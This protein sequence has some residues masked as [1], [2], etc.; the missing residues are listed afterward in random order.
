MHFQLPVYCPECNAIY[1]GVMQMVAGATV[2][3]QNVKFQCP[4]GHTTQMPDGT[5]EV[6]DG[7]VHIAAPGEESIPVLEK[8]RRLAQE[9]VEG[10]TDADTAIAAISEIAPSLAPLLKATK[11]SG[12][13]VVLALLLWFV[14]QM[15]NALQSER[16]SGTVVDNRP[17]VINQITINERVPK[18]TELA[19]TDRGVKHSKRKKRRLRGKEKSGNCS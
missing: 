8:I 11:G 19:P 13:L 1:G 7:V 10:K 15:T 3:M 9:A 12:A 17:T 16:R 5:I 6:R 2:V 14:V 18:A 4:R